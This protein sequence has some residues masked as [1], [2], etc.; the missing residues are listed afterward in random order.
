MKNSFKKIIKQN[1]KQVSLSGE[2]MHAMRVRLLDHIDATP[3]IEG[4]TWE[5]IPLRVSIFSFIKDYAGTSVLMPAFLLAVLVLGGSLTLTSAGALPGDMMYSMKKLSEKIDLFFAFTPGAEARVNVIQAVR[6][7]EEAEALSSQ[8]K[9]SGVVKVNL[10]NSFSAAS[11]AALHQIGLLESEDKSTGQRVLTEFRGNLSAHKDILQNIIALGDATNTNSLPAEVQS[12]IASL[13]AA[14]SSVIAIGHETVDSAIYARAEA[15]EQIANVEKYASVNMAGDTKVRALTGLIAAQASYEN[16]TQ[17]LEA[18]SYQDAVVLFK[19]ATEQA[20]QAK[21]AAQVYKAAK[22]YIVKTAAKK[23]IITVSAT[24]AGSVTLTTTPTA[25]S[26]AATTTPE[27]STTT[28]TTVN[29]TSTSG[30][31]NT[32]SGG[33]QVNINSS[34]SS[35]TNVNVGPVNIKLP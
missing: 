29:S 26:S 17:A 8:G 3:L 4:A 22:R 23:P 10:E 7:L 18:E 15:R 34:G 13:G 6:R 25:T 11:G 28:T 19:Q 14:T 24:G 1:A 32:G 21:A 31:V 20:L 12:V 35:G 9:L 27:T 16:G 30:S 33:T 5:D 2:E